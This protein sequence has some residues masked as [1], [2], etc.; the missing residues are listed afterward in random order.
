MFENKLAAID[1]K[2]SHPTSIQKCRQRQLTKNFRRENPEA[3]C[4]HSLRS[5]CGGD[6]KVLNSTNVRLSVRVRGFVLFLFEGFGHNPDHGILKNTHTSRIAGQDAAKQGQLLI[7]SA[8]RPLLQNIS[9]VSICWRGTVHTSRRQPPSEIYEA[10][11]GL[12]SIDSNFSRPIPEMAATRV[13]AAIQTF[14]GPK[15]HRSHEGE[16]ITTY[17]L[18]LD[19]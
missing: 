1:F 4:T 19:T 16:P 9:A 15:I 8:T 10:Y 11:V 3:C 7:W 12:R 13:R 5:R 6:K 18:V 2:V 14:P 17:R